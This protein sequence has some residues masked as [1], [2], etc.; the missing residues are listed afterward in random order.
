MYNTLALFCD[1]HI[2]ECYIQIDNTVNVNPRECTQP[3]FSPPVVGAI[4]PHDV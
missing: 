4:L 2:T 3:H 1:F